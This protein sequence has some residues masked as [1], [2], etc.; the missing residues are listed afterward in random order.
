[1]CALKLVHVAECGIRLRGFRV[2]GLK[3]PVLRGGE[4]KLSL[5]G[6]NRCQQQADRAGVGL[7]F[8][9]FLQQGLRLFGMTFQNAK[10]QQPLQRAQIRG[11]WPI[12]RRYSASAFA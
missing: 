7:F 9:I 10:L 12:K 4:I 2:L 11:A 1:M 6:S 3:P 5:P 8:E